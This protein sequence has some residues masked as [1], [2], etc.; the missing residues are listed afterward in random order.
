MY[1][2]FVNLKSMI[3][4]FALIF[5][6]PVHASSF[7]KWVDENG[8]THYTETPPEDPNVQ[9]TRIRA[10]GKMP[11]EADKAQERL[12]AQRGEFKKAARE[13][14]KYSDLSE[15]EAQEKKHQETIQKNCGQAKK[16]IE[17][18]NQNARVREQDKEGNLHYLT[19][20]E[21]QE[22]LNQ[23][24]KFLEENCKS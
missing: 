24:R 22:R 23:A 20:E 3:L 9:S 21:H 4:S 7:Y 6:A 1:S 5:G 17:T 14:E 2:E 8:V 11:S 10:S 19:P 18:L 13:R 12:E 16:N 15:K